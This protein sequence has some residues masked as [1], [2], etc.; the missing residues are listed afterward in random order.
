MYVEFGNDDYSPIMSNH[1]DFT[2]KYDRSK[3]DV[4]FTQPTELES[5]TSNTIVR[6]C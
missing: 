1:I 2:C 3:D 6:L 4:G 5:I